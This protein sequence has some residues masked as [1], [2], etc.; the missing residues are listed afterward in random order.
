MHARVVGRE[1]R[2]EVAD[3]AD[4]PEHLIAVPSVKGV[5]ELVDYQ[6]AG[7]R[8]TGGQSEKL[9]GAERFRSRSATARRTRRVNS[10]AE[11]PAISLLTPWIR[12]ESE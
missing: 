3:V 9:K 11:S 1:R 6:N 4:D 10:G 8:P 7:L 2:E 12:A 5:E